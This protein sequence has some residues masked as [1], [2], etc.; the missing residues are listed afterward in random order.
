MGWLS[1]FGVTLRQIG[2]PKV[3]EH[4][5][6]EKRPKPVRFHGRHVLKESDVILA[7]GSEAICDV[8]QEDWFFRVPRAVS[9]A[10]NWRV[11]RR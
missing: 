9:M 6:K 2:R 11:S 8:S 10:V 5:P 1:G 7:V 4:F 3:T